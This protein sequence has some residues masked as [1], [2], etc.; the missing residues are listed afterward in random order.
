MYTSYEYVYKNYGV[1]DSSF[2]PYI[3]RVSHDSNTSLYCV[4]H[5]CASIIYSSQHVS[6]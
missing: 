3:A 5:Q 4:Y 2:Y 6:L 1:D